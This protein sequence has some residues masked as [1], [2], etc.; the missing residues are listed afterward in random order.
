MY[1][2]TL[3]RI[4][5]RGPQCGG[6]ISDI[7]KLAP[8]QIDKSAAFKRWLD[9]F[10]I[11]RGNYRITE[12]AIDEL[13][14]TETRQDTVFTEDYASKERSTKT[15]IARPLTR[16]EI[17][18]LIAKKI[19]IQL[20]DGKTS[21]L[22][23]R[24]YVQQSKHL[25]W[26]SKEV[27]VTVIKKLIEIFEI[28][29]SNLS[30]QHLKKN[31][32]HTLLHY[33]KGPYLALVEAGYAYSKEEI[34]MHS[35]KTGFKM[36]KIYP[37]EITSA[38]HIYDN[39]DMRITAIKWGVFKYNQEPNKKEPKNV[40]KNDFE[41]IGLRGVAA[42]YESFPYDGFVEASYAYSEKEI[43]AHSHK[44][45]FATE[46]FYPWE[47]FYVPMGFYE[48]VSNRIVATRWL[49]WKLNNEGKKAK[50]ILYDDFEN[51][52]LAGVLE[53]YSSHQEAVREA[54]TI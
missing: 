52:G 18:E 6:T 9:L 40:T 10:F 54:L 7:H 1:Y 4:S 48:E 43:A 36:N 49:I 26:R 19:E 8:D 15:E 27:R 51:N 22:Y 12:K 14:P 29:P 24:G 37:W 35:K 39:A 41:A 21:E 28:N 53:Y 5:V 50:E 38:P 16:A 30:A 11:G 46:K 44:M 45:E 13:A 32:L 23:G 31:G 3:G 34:M 2:L 25:H 33:Y 42:H 20:R 47:M 17:R